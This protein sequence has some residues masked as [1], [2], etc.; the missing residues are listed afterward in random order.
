MIVVLTRN[1]CN[2]IN[3]FELDQAMAL[4]REGK[5]DDIIVVKIGDV[6]ANRVPVHLY[7]QMRN[8]TFLEWEDDIDAIDT[9]KGKLKDRLKN[10]NT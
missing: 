7:T 8:G 1:Y 3:E 5:L 10:T 4:Q 6:P 2:G 9:F